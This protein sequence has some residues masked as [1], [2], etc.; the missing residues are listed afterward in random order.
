M[1]RPLIRVRVGLH[2]LRHQGIRP[3]RRGDRLAVIGASSQR[4]SQPARGRRFLE[5]VVPALASCYNGITLNK[6]GEDGVFGISMWEVV[7]ILVVALV[8]LG[9]RQLTEVARTLGKLYR[10]VQKLAAD[11]RSSVD[12]DALTRVDDPPD[13][14]RQNYEP[15]PAV[16]DHD[17]TAPPGERSGPDFYADLLESSKEPEDKPAETEATTEPADAHHAAQE[18]QSKESHPQEKGDKPSPELK[19]EEPPKG[20]KS[21]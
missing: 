14:V 1:A 3:P 9:P 13:P 8:V 12:L 4:G 15:P 2:S 20:E 7:L 17:L 10:E 18:T 6:N 19:K 5:A 11:V 16:K 21:A